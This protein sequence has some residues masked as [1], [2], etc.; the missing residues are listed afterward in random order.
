MEKWLELIK[1][2]GVIKD[3]DLKNLKEAYE[4]DIELRINEEVRGLKAKRDE[5]LEKVA[6]YKNNVDNKDSI[7]LEEENDALRDKVIDLEKNIKKLESEKN[8]S[9]SEL[10]S[11]LESEQRAINSLLIDNGLTSE[12]TNLGVKKEHL[13]AVKALL[14][15]RIS[16][17]SEGDERYTIIK[18]KDKDNKEKESD[19]KEYLNNYWKTSEEGKAFIVITNSGADTNSRS[20]RYAPNTSDNENTRKIKEEIDRVQK[21][22]KLNPRD[23]AFKLIALKDQLKLSNN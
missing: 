7:K 12:L 11:K 23:K 4:S 6:R 19:I 9:V 18:Y 10:T 1:K 3:E 20:S 22:E 14:S 16:I 21:D 5:L 8:R 2:L 17:K 13:Q 15:P